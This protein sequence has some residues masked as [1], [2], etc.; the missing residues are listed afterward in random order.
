MDNNIFFKGKMP[1]G[2]M[3]V[4]WVLKKP[5]GFNLSDS[6][7]RIIIQ[8]S[9]EFSG[10]NYSFIKP[11]NEDLPN[12]QIYLIGQYL[13]TRETRQYPDNFGLVQK[14]FSY[15]SI[16]NY[17]IYI[18]NTHIFCMGNLEI[19]KDIL[20]RH[21]G[22]PNFVIEGID[23]DKIE[24]GFSRGLI[25][26]SGQRYKSEQGTLIKSVRKV[27]P[28]SFVCDESSFETGEDIDREYLEVLVTIDEISKRFNIYPNGKITYRGKF[29]QE[30]NPF[31]I[32]KRVYDK[33][34]DTI[35]SVKENE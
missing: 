21:S 1:Y 15:P 2:E 31:I 29:E 9:S 16:L 4:M 28:I 24:T 3:A 17:K 14:D 12:F 35:E 10:N 20:V 19:I 33:I 23:L 18:S 27:E 26:V 22:K 7:Q 32:M 5:N 11:L 8:S 25:G 34:L 6:Y 30:Q 13:E